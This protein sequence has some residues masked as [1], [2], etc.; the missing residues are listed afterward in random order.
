MNKRKIDYMS[1]PIRYINFSAD[2]NKFDEW[3]ENTNLIAGHK[4]ILGYPTK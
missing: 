1:G 4:V 3:K 2:Y